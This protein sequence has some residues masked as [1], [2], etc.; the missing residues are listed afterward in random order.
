MKIVPFGD[1]YV[2]RDNVPNYEVPDEEIAL[3][4]PTPPVAPNVG[5]SSGVG[6]FFSLEENILSMNRRLEELFLLSNFIMK[7][8]LG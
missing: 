4:D 7:K 3:S 2:H 8:L 6:S 1:L 5:S